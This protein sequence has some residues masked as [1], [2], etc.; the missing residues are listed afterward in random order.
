MFIDSNRVQILV[1][2]LRYRLDLG[3]Q[4][5]F[6][7]EHVMLIILSYEVDC[8]TQVTKSTRTS[9]SMQVGVRRTREIKVDDHIDRFNINTSGEEICAHQTSCLSI[10]EVMIDSESK[11]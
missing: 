3:V 8:N 1:N 11:Q 10:A 4:L 2:V 7:F 9:Y 6:D 5:I